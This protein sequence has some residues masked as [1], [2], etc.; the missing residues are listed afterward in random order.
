[1]KAQNTIWKI[2]RILY[3]VSEV[4]YLVMFS[5]ILSY[6]FLKTTQ[7]LEE[8]DIL[9][10]ENKIVLEL[11]SFF[12]LK[13]FVLLGIIIV[14][15]YLCSEK[16]NIKQYLVVAA[17]VFAAALIFQKHDSMPYALML[18]LL[19]VGAKD[20][21][22]HKLLKLYFSIII[23]FS[24]ITIVA[25]QFGIITNLVWNVEGR[26]T[27]I[28]FGFIYPTDFAAHL[29]FITLCYWYMR[30]ERLCYIEA[31]ITAILGG[32]AYLFCEARCSTL[33]LLLLSLVMFYFRFRYI[34]SKKRNMKSQIG[35]VFSLLLVFTPLMCSVFIHFF[36]IFFTTNIKYMQD[37]NKLIS[38]RLSLA[39]R[40]IDI[41]GFQLWGAD[42]PMIGNGSKET[43]VAKYFYIDSTY[44][45]LSLLYGVV[46]LT[47][48]LI[49][50]VLVGEEARKRKDWILLWIIALASVHGVIEQHLIELEYFPF[51]F[52]A[53][54]DMSRSKKKRHGKKK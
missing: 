13:P 35:S 22:F 48:I 16:Y 12:L 34:K 27:R 26:N 11:L 40:A 18:I 1:M 43:Y 33:M 19:L 10:T 38:G 5:V 30:G 53:F 14:L 54:A 32:L 21:S 2:K 44:L 41:F 29:F 8:W 25:A 23:F 7:F 49:I 45:Q 31:G 50:F 39:K 42:I 9:N 3:E 6:R 47:L 36:S 46:F 52:A 15:R 20:I 4:L 37:F 24:I 28:S 17:L 51:L